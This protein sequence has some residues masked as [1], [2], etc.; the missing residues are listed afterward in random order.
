MHRAR[1][2]V[3]LLAAL[4]LALL[5]L[6]FLVPTAGAQT[7]PAAGEPSIA[8]VT[9]IADTFLQDMLTL[10]LNSDGIPDF[11][12]NGDG[13]PE[14]PI[15]EPGDLDLRPGDGLFGT[16]ATPA[17]A[18]LFQF[19][20]VA[21]GDESSLL[22]NCSGMAMSF[23]GN[24]VMVDWAIGIGSSEGGGASGTII[25]LYPASESGQRAFTADN[26]FRVVDRVVY[27]GR[28]PTNGDGPRN[29]V[30]SAETAGISLDS[31]GDDNPNGNNRNAGEVDIGDD[32]PAGGFLIPSGVFPFAG[33]LMSQNGLRCEGAGWVQFDTGNPVASVAGLA[34]TGLGVAGIFG[35]LFNARPA[36]TWR[37]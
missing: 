6:G 25:D 7:D 22:F 31:G 2:A 8:E 11:D 13:V 33:E 18:S 4:T 14:I 19:D 36:V 26:P 30:W 23:D 34:A 37:A 35:L 5:P 1:R 29:H 16:Q 10:D 15:G 27:F 17:V 9:A 21:I 32:T 3:A 24:G 12:T 20:P 28:L